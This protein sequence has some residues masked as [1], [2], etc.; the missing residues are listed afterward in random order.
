MKNLNGIGFEYL[1]RDWNVAEED[2]FKDM[3]EKETTA[4]QEAVTRGYTGDCPLRVYAENSNVQMKR[5][6]FALVFITKGHRHEHGIFNNAPWTK[7]IETYRA[8]VHS[9]MLNELVEIEGDLS[10]LNFDILRT[11]FSW[12]NPQARPL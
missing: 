12:E 11:L 10:Q 8:W 1:D 7:G 5:G 3:N 9:H 4:M 6:K 2:A